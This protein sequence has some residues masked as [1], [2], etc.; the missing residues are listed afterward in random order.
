MTKNDLVIKWW[1]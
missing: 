1:G